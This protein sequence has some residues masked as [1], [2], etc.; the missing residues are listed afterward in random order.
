LASDGKPFTVAS[1]ESFVA[2]FWPMFALGLI[3]VASLPLTF[4]PM[5]D[6]RLQA[7]A[8]TV[9]LGVLKAL[10][11]IQ[12][13]MLLAL[14]AALGAALAHRVGLPSHVVGINIRRRFASECPAAIGLGLFGGFVVVALDRLVFRTEA[15]ALE[16][17]PWRN[18]VEGLLGG[19]LYGGLTEEVMM[20]WGL[21]SFIAWTVM[22]VFRNR[23]GSAVPCVAA[24]VISAVA[25]GAG[26]L[27]AA[28]MISPLDRAL[29]TRI[30]GLNAFAGLIFG[31]LYW[32]RS[33]EAAML[34]HMSMHAAFALAR[35]SPWA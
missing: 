31:G 3:G 8:P 2:R 9:P 22:K 5:L 17:T 18:I 13:A 10:T 26:H 23:P 34:A 27:P 11:L 16:A 14:G 1:A 12:P 28:S 29:A 33:I 32:R 30:I 21:M 35:L 19:V 7:A 15:I 25:F 20:R 4:P 6:A 24:I